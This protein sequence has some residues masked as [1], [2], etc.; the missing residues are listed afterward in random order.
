MHMAIATR[1][2][3]IEEVLALPEDG[4]R[5]EVIEGQFFVTP[6]PRRE[7]QDA[8]AELDFLLRAY[9]KRLG[10][11]RVYQSPSDVRRGS[12]T[13][14]QPDLY[15]IPL[16]SGKVP[17]DWNQLPRL[18]LVVEVLSPFS[19]RADRT[20]KRRLYQT[21]GIPEYWIVDVDARVIERWRTG[22]SR[23]EILS[24][25][26]EWQPDPGHQS[27]VIDLVELFGS[28]PESE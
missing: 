20:I 13:M 5:Y 18:L 6:S 11:G 2:W 19:A 27:L 25:R 24:D 26:L 23:P 15:V 10:I 14:V 7:H 3:T 16:V 8:L 1:E 17:Q 28:I 4:N 21:S 9:L 22:D 12:Q